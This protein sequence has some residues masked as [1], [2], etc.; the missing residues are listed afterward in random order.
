MGRYRYHGEHV[1]RTI[2]Q[3]PCSAWR[4]WCG[5]VAAMPL[6]TAEMHS[7]A[8]LS[9]GRQLFRGPVLLLLT[10]CAVVLCLR[11]PQLLEILWGNVNE[12][13]L[14]KRWICVSQEGVTMEVSIA[15][16]ES[17]SAHETIGRGVAGAL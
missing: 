2:V 4:K 16:G 14:L 12:A 13:L 17:L 15:A 10:L 7:E 1:S 6:P 11:L 3:S 9:A 8:D 5:I